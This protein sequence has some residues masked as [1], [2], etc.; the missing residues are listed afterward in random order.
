MDK[1]LKIGIITAEDPAD[2]K[3]W[4]GTYYR[5]SEAL[6]NEFTT[7]VH[8]GPVKLSRFNSFLMKTQ[9]LLSYALHK[10]MYN[11]NF[12]IRH[13]FILSKYHGK[14]FDQKLRQL[15]VDVVFAPTASSEIALLKTDIP[16]CYFSDATFS[17][18]S[19]YYGAYSNLS[20]K[21]RKESND[22]QQKALSRS[23]T[24]VYP[25]QWAL[26]SSVK[27]YG[28]KNTFLIKMGA[29]IDEDP[30]EQCLQKDYESTIN[31]LFVGVDWKR[32]GGDIALETVEK[33]VKK[34]H[35]VQLT[36]CGCIPPLKHPKM[37][38][39]PFLNKNKKEDMD[40]FKELFNQAHLFFM[41]T[42]SECY[43]IVFCEANAYGIPVITTDTGGVPSVVENGVNGHMLPISAGSDEYVTLIENII[44]D[45]DVLKKMSVASREK[46]LNELNWNNWGKEMKKVLLTTHRLANKSI[47]I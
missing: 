30:D 41:P 7:V 34:G 27:D 21:S 18:M 2:K 4:S 10:L 20:E 38:V 3:S 1:N 32:K 5:M 31:I 26:D 9:I 23:V 39:V 37:T 22:I 45:K 16:I 42:R 8:L 46:Y 15:D 11:K 47:S 43:G 17:L 6:K 40:R 12:N 13:N 24:K 19:N 29:N 44:S 28:S 36:V 35:D 25:S 33:L 14:Y